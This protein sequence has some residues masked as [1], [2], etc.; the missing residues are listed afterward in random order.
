MC[1]TSDLMDGYFDGSDMHLTAW[2]VHPPSSMYTQQPKSG[3]EAS[4][5]NIRNKLQLVDYE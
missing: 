2:V 5:L 3:H 1:Q 4:L